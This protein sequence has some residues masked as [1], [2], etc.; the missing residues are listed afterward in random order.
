[1]LIFLKPPPK[2]H[3]EKKQRI[4][5]ELIKE[6]Q[7]MENEIERLLGK[8][9]F[10]MFIQRTTEMK[11]GGDVHSKALCGRRWQNCQKHRHHM[12]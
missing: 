9:K 1:M 4:N 10:G 5:G 2:C 12:N 3:I 8:D 6:N 7:S 11:S